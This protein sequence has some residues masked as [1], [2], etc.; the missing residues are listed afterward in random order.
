M[1]QQIAKKKKKSL[2]QAEQWKTAID[3][4]H[5]NQEEGYAE[6]EI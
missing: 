2:Q 6:G 5:V 3:L 1:L 4:L